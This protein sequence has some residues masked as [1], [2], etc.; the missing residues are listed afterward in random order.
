M[1]PEEFRA[2]DEKSWEHVDEQNWDYECSGCGALKRTFPP[3]YKEGHYIWCPHF[4]D[5]PKYKEQAS[6]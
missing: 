1:T 2:I 4:K 6:L 5:H 3:A